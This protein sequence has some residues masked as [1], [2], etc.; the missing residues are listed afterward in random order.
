MATHTVTKWPEVQFVHEIPI[1]GKFIR[2]VF[3][4]GLGFGI[5]KLAKLLGAS[6]QMV[7]ISKYIISLY[8]LYS[9]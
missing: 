9:T 7:I 2:E 3:I 4:G 1:I 8:S 5:S 6:C